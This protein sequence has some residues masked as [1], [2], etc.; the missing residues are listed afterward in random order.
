MVSMD[1]VS[2]S[3]TQKA[4]LLILL[5]PFLL[6]WFVFGF[7][8]GLLNLLLSTFKTNLFSLHFVGLKNY[9]RLLHDVNFWRAMKNSLRYLLIVPILQASALVVAYGLTKVG[10]LGK[11]LLLAYYIPVILS[12]VV[13]SALFKYLL[14]DYGLINSILAYLGLPKVGWLSDP[15]I[16]L[17]S[18]MTVTFWKGLGYYAVIYYSSL[19]SLPKDVI[20]AAILDGASEFTLLTR[21]IAPMI[22]PTIAFCT[23]ISSLAALKV[24]AEIYVMTGGGPAGSTL[25]LMMYVYRSAF[26]ELQFGYSAA[27]SSILSLL[28]LAITVTLLK[29]YYMKRYA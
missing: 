11:L 22:L 16:A 28:S 6:L 19:L 4:L 17:Y 1:G 8:P 27:I 20:E 13:L 7:L 23:L 18:V 21:F 26:S 5:L 12:T 3:R 14:S 15:R 2:G 9:V 25:T 24:F 29:A 10:R